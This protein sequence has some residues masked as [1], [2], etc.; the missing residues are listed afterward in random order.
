[1]HSPP[2]AP[3]NWRRE[4]FASACC[5]IMWPCKHVDLEPD[6]G[7][8]PTKKILPFHVYTLYLTPSL[9]MSFTPPVDILTGLNK[10]EIILETDYNELY[11][12][13]QFKFIL[14]GFCQASWIYFIKSWKFLS[15]FKKFWL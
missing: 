6:L 4:L 1:M 14:S 10:L 7:V 15:N 8:Q 5:A 12:L 11:H 13:E 9:L 2:C 3:N